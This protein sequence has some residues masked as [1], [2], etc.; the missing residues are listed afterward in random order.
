MSLESST[1]EKQ[2]HVRARSRVT[3]GVS[4]FQDRKVDQ[5]GKW[6]R[7]FVDLYQLHCDDIGGVDRMSE[8]QKSL[9]R[10]V[11]SL[12]IE[13]ERI[14]NALALGGEADIDLYSRVANSLRRMLEAIGIERKAKL[15]EVSLADIVR[16]H[17]EK[18]AGRSQAA[19]A[20]L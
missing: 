10:R 12:E 15:V 7:R 17:Q 2:R 8:A 14:E 3:N 4:L 11:C 1:V 18:P 13:L 19:R 16:Q 5:R 6:A 20:T 9:V